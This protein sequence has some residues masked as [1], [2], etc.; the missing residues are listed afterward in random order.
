MNEMAFYLAASCILFSICFALL[1]RRR[2]R[3]I[4]GRM[5]AMVDAAAKGCFEETF[6]DETRL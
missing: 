3:R 1:E 2:V 4:M 5:E 6:F